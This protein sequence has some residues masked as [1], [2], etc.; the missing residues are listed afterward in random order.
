MGM[1]STSSTK[2]GFSNATDSGGNSDTPKVGNSQTKMDAGSP[3]AAMGMESTS[4]FEEGYGDAVVGG[5]NSDTPKADG[6]SQKNR[7]S[8]GSSLAAMG[9][10][11]TLAVQSY[12]PAAVTSP[13]DPT[14]SPISPATSDDYSLPTSSPV[15][16]QAAFATHT[17]EARALPESSQTTQ[18]HPPDTPGANTL[19]SRTN[20]YIGTV[21]ED[22]SSVDSMSV[23]LGTADV[24]VD[25]TAVEEGAD[26][27]G[28]SLKLDEHWA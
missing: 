24:P 10:A 6:N 16:Q 4:S 20:S 21:D 12:T 19:V 8:V 13:G 14:H 18:V 2:E 23:S 5:G 9:M 26:G 11:S 22:D 15:P 3:L 27:D 25:T 28:D 1:T 7:M 17:M